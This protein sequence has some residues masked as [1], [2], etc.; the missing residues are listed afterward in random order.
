MYEVLT[1][2]ATST[3]QGSGLGRIIA[4]FL[5]DLHQELST[6]VKV[7]SATDSLPL[8]ERFRN[9]DADRL[10][11]NV[12][13]IVTTVMKD[14]GISDHEELGKVALNNWV[15]RKKTVF[16][17]GDLWFGTLLVDAHAALSSDTAAKESAND[18]TLTVGICDWEFAG[19][20]DPAADIAQLGKSYLSNYSLYVLLMNELRLIF[21]FTLDV[22]FDHAQRQR[23]PVC[24]G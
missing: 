15:G 3:H 11:T 5:A 9:E 8:I 21:A 24:I 14:A 17:Q 6:D 19:P 13:A 16:G 7:A 20:N 22:T 18:S 12:I 2:P 1:S 23:C 4:Q 10:M